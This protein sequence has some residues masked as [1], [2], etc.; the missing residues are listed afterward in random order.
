M[1]DGQ[2]S[3]EITT[4]NSPSCSRLYQKPTSRSHVSCFR[5]GQ[6]QVQVRHRPAT[7]PLTDEWKVGPELP[8]LDRRCCGEIFC[9][10]A[11]PDTAQTPTSKARR[12]RDDRGGERRSSAAAAHLHTCAYDASRRTAGGVISHTDCKVEAAARS[13]PPVALS[14][15]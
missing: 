9:L 13:S 8:R 12:I 14:D 3:G 11:A 6:M 2:Q 4:R 5:F 10:L 7:Y 15:Q 1:C